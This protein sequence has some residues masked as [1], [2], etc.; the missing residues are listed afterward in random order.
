MTC[1]E[2]SPLS[3][4]FAPFFVDKIEVSQTMPRRCPWRWKSNWTL[5]PSW[6]VNCRRR[7]RNCKHSSPR[8]AVRTLKNLFPFCCVDSVY[9]CFYICI[10]C[11]HL[12]S[13]LPSNCLSYS[14]LCCNDRRLRRNVVNG[15]KSWQQLIAKYLIHKRRLRIWK[16]MQN[17]THV[18]IWSVARLEWRK[19]LWPWRN[20]KRKFVSW[21]TWRTTVMAS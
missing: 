16:P 13:P 2:S 6:S 12:F 7:M 3:F 8:W 9:I 15:K 17:P 10:I 14:F 4:F 20:W 5:Q 21:K 18:S 1:H 19:R 11:L